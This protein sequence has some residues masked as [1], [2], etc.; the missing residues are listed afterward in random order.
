[1]INPRYGMLLNYFAGQTP[2]LPFGQNTPVRPVGPTD[3]TGAGA[4]VP[5]PSSPKPI[6]TIPPVQ[7][8]SGRAGGNTLVAHCI[9]IMVPIETC[10]GY[11]YAPSLQI[12][13]R[14]QHNTSDSYTQS[15]VMQSNASNTPMPTTIPGSHR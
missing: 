12:N 7:S 11:G 14:L 6:V 15:N 8:A 4:M 5:F 13:S 1:M 10:I 2:P 9:P 3:Q